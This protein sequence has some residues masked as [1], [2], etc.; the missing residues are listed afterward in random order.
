[1][2]A[3]HGLVSD[4]YQDQFNTLAGQRYRLRRV[5]GYQVFK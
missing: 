2:V 1:M 5:S 4:A 3:R